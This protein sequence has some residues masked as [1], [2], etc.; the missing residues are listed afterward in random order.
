MKNVN[1]GMTIFEFQ[2]QYQTRS[3]REA[4]L[5]AMSN[6]EIDEIIASC[7]TNQGKS[8]YASFKR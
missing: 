8:Y 1:G 2:G 4:A 3:K 5:R 6:E 7:G